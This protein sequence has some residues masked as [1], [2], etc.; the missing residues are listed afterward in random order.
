MS[1]E[2]VPAYSEP[3]KVKE[4]FSEYTSAL[5]EKSPKFKEYL[6]IQHYDDEVVHMEVKYGLPEGRLYLAYSDGRLAGCVGLKDFDGESCE[7]KRMYVRPEFRGHHFGEIMLTKIIDDAKE[8]GYKYILLDT[9]PFLKRAIHMYKKY[10]FYEIPSYN[11]SP[12][13]NLVYMKLELN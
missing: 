6:A 9:F 7:I 12:M 10:G 3:E 11:G 8:I 13:E 1:F 2:M 5:V 4:L